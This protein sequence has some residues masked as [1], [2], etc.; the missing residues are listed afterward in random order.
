MERLNKKCLEIIENM[1]DSDKFDYNQMG[2]IALG[3]EKGLDI[4]IY[5]KPEFSSRQ[6][7]EIRMGLKHEIDVSL[8]TNPEFTRFQM[9]EI[10]MGLEKGL[11]VSSLL[12]KI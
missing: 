7:P 3:L 8:Y 12:I 6:M 5:A 2:Q 4:S 1:S 10:R 9:E 11:D